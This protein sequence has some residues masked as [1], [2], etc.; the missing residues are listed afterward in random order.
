MH[1]DRCEHT[2]TGINQHFLIRLH[3]KEMIKMEWIKTLNQAI[4]Y[5]ENNLSDH[6]TSDDIAKHVYLSNFHFQRVFSLLTGLTVGEYMRNRRLSLAGHDLL[7]GNDKIIDVALKYGY[8]TPE[9]FTKAFTR[10]HGVTPMEARKQGTI[11]KSFNRLVLKIKLEGGSCMDYRIEN[12]NEF[13]VV[14]KTRLFSQE[15]SSVEIPKFWSEYMSSGLEEQVCGMFGICFEDD[16]PGDE[17]RYGIGAEKEYVKEVPE[18]FEVQ[19]IPAHTW[20]IFPCVG[21][22]PHAIQNLWMKVY[23]EWLPTSN[24][25]LIP[26]FTIENYEEGDASQEDYVCEIW[27][28]VKEKTK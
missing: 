1:R 6:I 28:P 17:W 11:I 24:Y 13:E 8:D 14:L 18:G 27:L 20:V 3:Y 16:R 21:A 12:K 25:E 10:F 2:Q 19:T 9:G 4:D 15:T 22:M 7:T 26:D 23:S 5:M